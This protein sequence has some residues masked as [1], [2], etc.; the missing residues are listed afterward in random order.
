MHDAVAVGELHKDPVI[1]RVK[2]RRPG[3]ADKNAKGGRVT[4]IDGCR[5]ACTRFSEA[6]IVARVYR[7]R[8]YRESTDYESRC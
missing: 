1:G 7:L 3:A 8:S 4:G 5:D 2:R 6:L